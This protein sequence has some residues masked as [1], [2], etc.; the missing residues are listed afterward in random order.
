MT[1]RGLGI[2][3]WVGPTRRRHGFSLAEQYGSRS[4]IDL[5]ADCGNYIVSPWRAPSSAHWTAVR[6]AHPGEILGFFRK[7]ASRSAP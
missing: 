4:P 3:D 5:L 7:T 2:G 1:E 6:A